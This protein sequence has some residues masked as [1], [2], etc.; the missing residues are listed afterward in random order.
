MV[1]SDPSSLMHALFGIQKPTTLWS[2]FDCLEHYVLPIV[3][4]IDQKEKTLM[5]ENC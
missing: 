4:I 3:I 2:V 1:T 5:Q